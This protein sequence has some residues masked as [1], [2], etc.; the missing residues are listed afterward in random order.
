M[1]SQP[2]FEPYLRRWHLVADGAE[3]AT[4]TSRLLPVMQAGQPAMLKLSHAEEERSGQDLL[5]WWDGDGAAR[6]LADEDGALLIER[7][8]G[9]RSLSDM[10]RGGQD[11]EACRILCATAARLH[12]P[13]SKPLPQLIPLARRFDAL[14]PAARTHGGMLARCLAAANI[15]LA[16]PQDPVVL[17]GDLHHGNVLDFGARGWLAIDPKGLSGERGFDFANIFLNP[18]LADPSRPVAT[19]PQRFS[20]RL[21]TV[22]AAAGI[23]RARLLLWVL[24]WSGL[25]MAWFLEDGTPAPIN[26]HIAGLAAAELDR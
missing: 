23:E 15:L 6:V 20:Q 7:A 9:A 19:D 26:L 14:E 13:R 24:A 8:T 5:A 12:V 22:S 25:S 17:H 18:D 21:A 2:R 10:A 1:P 3:I 4:S 11:D 16:A